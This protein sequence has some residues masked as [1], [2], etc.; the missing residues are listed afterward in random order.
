MRYI[1]ICIRSE[2]NYGANM[3]ATVGDALTHQ[4]V[5]TQCSMFM[6]SIVYFFVSC[7]LYFN[8]TNWISSLFQF[9]GIQTWN[10]FGANCENHRIDDHCV[11]DHFGCIYF[12]FD[13]FAGACIMRSN[14]NVGLDSREGIN[15]GDTATGEFIGAFVPHCFEFRPVAFL[16]NFPRSSA[17]V[18][19]FVAIKRLSLRTV[20]S[21]VNYILHPLLLPLSSV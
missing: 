17:T 15:V 13:V 20:T 19:I 7:F 8:K 2:S 12:G 16:R 9:A 6:I 11:V 1:L 21:P 3:T 18:V 5:G 4:R 10:Q 14:A